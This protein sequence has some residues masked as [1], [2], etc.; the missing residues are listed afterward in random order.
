MNPAD[1]VDM[2]RREAGAVQSELDALNR[3]IQD[4]ESQSSGS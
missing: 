1:E 2:L 4:L 3:R